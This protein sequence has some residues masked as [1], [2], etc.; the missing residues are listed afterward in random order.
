MTLNYA[1]QIDRGKAQ[2]CSAVNKIYPF[3]VLIIRSK[4][5]C[6][7]HKTNEDE[8]TYNVICF[9]YGLHDMSRPTN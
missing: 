6:L 7:N 4:M 5:K 9:M 1:I 3:K 8:T 2:N